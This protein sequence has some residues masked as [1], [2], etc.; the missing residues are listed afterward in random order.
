ME[1]GGAN[2]SDLSQVD[3]Q[4]MSAEEQAKTLAEW[5]QWHAWN[6]YQQY[7]QVQAQDPNAQYYDQQQQQQQQQQVSVRDRCHYNTSTVNHI[8]RLIIP[9][10]R[11]G[12][13]DQQQ[14]YAQQQQQQQYYQQQQYFQQQQVTTQGNNTVP[15]SI[16]S[17]VNC[18]CSDKNSIMSSPLSRLHMGLNYFHCQCIAV[19]FLSVWTDGPLRGLRSLRGVRWATN[20]GHAP[21]GGLWSSA[22]RI[23]SR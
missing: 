4:S 11:Q 21:A 5:E 15:L 19:C 6:A 9:S 1:N 16:S 8:P 22:S 2:P 12:Y 17:N 14:Q 10:S 3:F 20:D 13:Y 7:Q 18:E 23:F